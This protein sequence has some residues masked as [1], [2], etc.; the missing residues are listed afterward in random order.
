MWLPEDGKLKTVISQIQGVQSVETRG[1]CTNTCPWECLLS[2]SQGQ[3]QDYTLK[4]RKKNSLN[5]LK[6][7]ISHSQKQ[8]QKTTIAKVK[9]LNRQI[10]KQTRETTDKQTDRQTTKNQ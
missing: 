1:K 8:K 2:R 3:S 10:D 7:L 6:A 5:K 9:V 4:V